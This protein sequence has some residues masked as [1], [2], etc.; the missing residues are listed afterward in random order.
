MQLVNEVIQELGPSLDP[1]DALL[2]KARY[3]R[4]ATNM[5]LGNFDD[6]FGETAA[7][8]PS[9]PPAQ[10]ATMRFR[11]DSLNAY[12]LMIRGQ[13]EDSLSAYRVLFDNPSNDVPEAIIARARIGYAVVLNENGRA[14]E[15]VD[16]YEQALTSA[17]RNQN[18]LI[19]L[20]AGNNLIV[21]LI[22]LKDYAAAQQTLDQLA[23]IRTRHPD[24]LVSGSLFLHEMEL[25]RLAGDA[26]QAADGL[27]RFIDE[28]VDTTPLMLGSAHQ[29]LAESLR[30]LEQLDKAI[31]HGAQAVDLLADQAHE[32]T[33]ARLSLAE[34]LLQ[35]GN[36]NAAA[37]LLNQ[38]DPT[39][40][41]V[42]TTLVDYGR[43]TLLTKL[44]SIDDASALRAFDAFVA[45]HAL[46]DAVVS[47]TR[48]E[49]FDSRLKVSEQAFALQKAQESAR[50]EALQRERDNRENRLLLAFVVLVA[51][52]VVL[53]VTSQ[54]RRSSEK[55][56]LDEKARLNQQAEQN[57]RF[58]AIGMLAGNVAHDFNNL[59]Q[60]VASSNDTLRSNVP[61][62]SNSNLSAIELSEQALDHGK[63]IVRQL[64]T[65]SRSNE[66]E[67]KPISFSAYLQETQT[68]LASALG[69]ERSL[70]IDDRSNNLF[71]AAD[72]TQLT[73]SVLNLIRN[74]VDAMPTG[75][76]VVLAATPVTVSNAEHEWAPE[77][78]P[79]R[80]L[81][82]RVADT[83]SGMSE[84][85]LERSIEPFF[86]TK[87]K[88]S[89]SGLG[90]S[91]V[92]AF[93]RQSGGDLRIRS[94]SGSG[95]T[96]ELILPVTEAPASTSTIISGPDEFRA[97]DL[98][99]LMVEDNDMLAV[100]LR[101]N[102]A[103]L[104]VN[105]IH[106]AS[107]DLAK[108]WLQRA[109]SPIDV[110]LTDIRMPGTINGLDLARWAAS[111]FPQ[112]KIVLMSGYIDQES[113]PRE[114][115]VIRKPF[116]IAELAAAIRDDT[117]TSS[118]AA[119]A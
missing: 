60:V 109:N 87:D 72:P 64:L 1:Q 62:D 106:L 119:N 74:S 4:A 16:M 43:L 51:V 91:S 38:I 113:T 81:L 80:Y 46:K 13:Q 55:R 32:V 95:T 92:Y 118:V 2:L 76:E 83:G 89:G 25:A 104:D 34:T 100:A 108:D 73:T 94:K 10:Q 96:V 53:L 69:V 30:D 59:L 115:T 9:I 114:F 103:A 71:I 19:S 40:E 20:F 85:V 37:E 75:G 82:L 45:A 116:R 86:T 7:L 65:F 102:L 42:P 112:L 111:R 110:L 61:G 12:L 27:Q 28:G 78:S 66:L 58:E 23:A 11:C 105:V 29:L 21:I 67:A 56:L 24:S 88:Q 68:L 14:G 50:F 36:V 39:A 93:A 57:K 79:G 49:Y 15:A 18:D 77:V 70:T 107:A 99:V 117:D 33:D 3:L 90:L 6:S 63:K 47:T 5:R 8:C 31:D 97:G 101:K 22:D 48:S 44:K 98:T 54:L 52:L 41:T 35:N 84:N 26:E 17:I